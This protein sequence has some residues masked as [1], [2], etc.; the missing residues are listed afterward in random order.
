MADEKQPQD[1]IPSLIDGL[2][3]GVLLFDQNL[4]VLWMNQA[5]ERLFGLSR[6]TTHGEDL[7]TFFNDQIIPRITNGGAFRE[8]VF[9]SVA[10]GS[11]VPTTELRLSSGAGQQ[12]W[13]EFSSQ[14]IEHGPFKG[15]RLDIYQ[16]ITLRK[17]LQRGID[18]HVGQLGEMIEGRTEELSRTA[19]ELQKESNERKH[20]E[21]LLGKEKEFSRQ[22]LETSPAFL[23]A[24]DPEGTIRM[25]SKSLLRSLNREKDQILESPFFSTFLP[26]EDEE[27]A[28]LRFRTLVANPVPAVE[29]YRM[30]TREGSLR[31][32]EWHLRPVCKEDR[33]VEFVLGVGIDITDRKAMEGALKASEDLYRT[34]FEAT[35]AATVIIDRESTIIQANRAFSRLLGEEER[36]LIGQKLF[37]IVESIDRGTLSTLLYRAQSTKDAFTSGECR[38]RRT[39]GPS[40]EV[41]VTVSSI[42]ATQRSVLSFLDITERKRAERELAERNRFL[43]IIH[44]M[45][46]AAT[47]S[48]S[49]EESLTTLLEKSLQ[50]LEYD[51]G[52]IYLMEPDKKKA[53][54]TS[55]RG[56]PD[57]MV[58]RAER[59]DIQE[60]PYHQIFIEGK[61]E[62]RGKNEIG[63]LSMAW[64]P[65]L[66]DSDVI[67]AVHFLTGRQEAFSEQEK[68]ILESLSREV[69]NA[70]RCGILKEELEDSNTL[71]NLYL[72]I[73]T[74]DINNANSVSLMYAELLVDILEG[75]NREIAQ[76]L[77]A[78]IRRSSDIITNVNLLRKIREEKVTLSPLALDEVVTSALE[79]L[80]ESRVRY[81][82]VG[83]QVCA[84]P[85][86]SEVFANLV[87]NSLKF[88]G[89][90]VVVTI[91]AAEMD[92]E[93]E[94][95]V[96]DTGPGIP[97]SLKPLLF[98]RF[99]RG[100]SRVRGRGL[101]LYLCRMLMERYG[102]RIWVEDRVSGHPE[103]GVTFKFRI[104]KAGPGGV[105]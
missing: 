16:D 84:D 91:S 89:K 66:T 76:K 87:G 78:G 14:V 47:S 72:D 42:P 62:Y 53:R 25:V 93:V 69:G 83:L 60:D 9:S 100:K 45:I 10:S 88:G 19:E 71:A 11:P 36:S 26:L 58:R 2:D 59:L 27:P 30:R 49:L 52:A 86:L 57:W 63:L 96:S 18:R 8:Q 1:S 48:K 105:C 32:V 75:E 33:T 61:T 6:S 101:G 44:Q 104:R 12:V 29:D 97:D 65:F 28:F 5:M 80:P 31:I 56:M 70:I 21:E 67:G 22:I 85:L 102:G 92:A 95:V 17:L 41:V 73:M 64:I 39:G 54:L 35:L 24:L 79:A 43:S 38:L 50:L 74:H 40:R 7:F 4:K 13:V 20:A 68:T 46:T 81:I 77:S 103:Q 94:V 82:P 98:R 34:I 99:E 37:E 90:G 23:V 51:A 55:H 15:M 3:F